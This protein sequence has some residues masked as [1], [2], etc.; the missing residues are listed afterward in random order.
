MS[1]NSDVGGVVLDLIG[2]AAVLEAARGMLA[3]VRAAHPQARIQGFA[4]QPMVR[5]PGA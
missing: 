3:R 2:P 5:R 1:G 4:V